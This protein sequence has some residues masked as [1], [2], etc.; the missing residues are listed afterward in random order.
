V[1][2]SGQFAHEIRDQMQRDFFDQL[3]N[4]AE[5]LAAKVDVA[6]RPCLYEQV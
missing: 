6:T 1:S 5:V 4:G 2:C 3:K